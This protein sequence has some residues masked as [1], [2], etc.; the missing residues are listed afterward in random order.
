MTFREIPGI[1]LDDP[2]MSCADKSSIEPL[3]E[4]Q[5]SAL[6]DSYISPRNRHLML[7]DATEWAAKLLADGALF[8]D[9]LEDWNADSP[10]EF[11]YE[12]RQLDIN[13]RDIVPPGFE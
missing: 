3:D 7:L 12:L 8:Y 1:L 10:N 2:P 11:T 5:A 4:T 6:W 9:W 13:A